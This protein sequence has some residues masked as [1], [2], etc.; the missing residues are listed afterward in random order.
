MRVTERRNCRSL[1]EGTVVARRED[2]SLVLADIGRPLDTL[3]KYTLNTLRR[4]LP[5]SA[6]VLGF[7]DKIAQAVGSRHVLLG[8]GT[9]SRSINLMSMHLSDEQSV[10]SGAAKKTSLAKYSQHPSVRNILS[11]T[12]QRWKALVSL[13]Q[14]EG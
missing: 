3:K 1:A 2:G 13:I 11:D 7:N 4:F 14:K 9:N 8:E 10:S 5:K 6:N 12:P